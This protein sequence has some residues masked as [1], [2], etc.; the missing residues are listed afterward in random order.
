MSTKSPTDFATDIFKASDSLHATPPVQW[1]GMADKLNAQQ[2]ANLERNATDAA[3]RA[4]AL[5]S[6]LGARSNGHPHA[7]AVKVMN[8]AIVLADQLFDVPTRKAS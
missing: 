5:A 2:L 7:A 8:R 1:E 6:Y 3:I 4:T